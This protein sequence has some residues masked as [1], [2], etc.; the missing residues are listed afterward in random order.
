MSGAERIDQMK[1]Q[2]DRLNLAEIQI[3][4]EIEILTQFLRGYESAKCALGGPY[5]VRAGRLVQAGPER[6]EGPASE[7]GP[8]TRH[9]HLRGG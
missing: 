1:V 9:S 2:R 8:S 5:S 7:A 4:E 6:V 3:L